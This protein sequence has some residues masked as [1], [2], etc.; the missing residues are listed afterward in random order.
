MRRPEHTGGTPRPVGSESPQPTVTLEFVGKS[1]RIA[2]HDDDV[3]LALLDQVGN[4]ASDDTRHR[5]SHLSLVDTHKLRLQTTV[6]TLPSK[7]DESFATSVATRVLILTA[8]DNV[9]LC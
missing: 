7:V 4:R 6:I 5:Q 1:P 2:S 8:D 3:E 9:P